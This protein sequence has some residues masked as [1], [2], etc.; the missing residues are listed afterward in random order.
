MFISSW[1]ALPLLAAVV[2]GLAGC[3]KDTSQREGLGTSSALAPVKPPGSQKT[4]SNPVNDAAR[5]RSKPDAGTLLLV[6]DDQHLESVEVTAWID[7]TFKEGVRLLPINDRQF[8]ALGS[9]ALYTAG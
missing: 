2:P 6:G 9:K 7:A 5:E 8:L 4:A 3:S 1:F